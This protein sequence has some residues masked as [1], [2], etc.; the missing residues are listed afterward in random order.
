VKHEH[1]DALMIR[2]SK[3]DTY[4]EKKAQ[5]AL[6]QRMV[7]MGTTKSQYGGACEGVCLTRCGGGLVQRLSHVRAA[8][9]DQVAT[10]R[11]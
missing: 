2:H 6:T 9:S 3:R 1:V 8:H 7:G 10:H 4:V 11:A 5:V